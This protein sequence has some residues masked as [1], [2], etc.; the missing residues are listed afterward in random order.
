MHALEEKGTG[1][2]CVPVQQ[3]GPGC[4]VADAGGIG[5]GGVAPRRGRQDEGQRAQAHPAAQAQPETLADT[6][7]LHS[8]RRILM[9]CPAKDDDA[10]IR[11]HVLVM[12]PDALLPPGQGPV[13]DVFPGSHVQPGQAVDL[14][15]LVRLRRPERGLA[16]QHIGLVTA[17][18]GTDGA[19]A[20]GPVLPLHIETRG[21]QGRQQGVQLSVRGAVLPGDAGLVRAGSRS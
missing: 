13:T 4:L 9:P 14:H 3:G 5:E 19:Q 16:V 6:A 2:P 18:E 10:H 12:G 20:A 8:G 7:V 21:G 1:T 17:M 11:G 15:I